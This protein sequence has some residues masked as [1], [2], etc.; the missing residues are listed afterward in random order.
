MNVEVVVPANVWP[1]TR[2]RAS[3]VF[4]VTCDLASVWLVRFPAA[5]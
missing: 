5:S 3:Y 2:S 4:V 1:T